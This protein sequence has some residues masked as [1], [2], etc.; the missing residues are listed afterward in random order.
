MQ[1]NALEMG[2][3]RG[4]LFAEATVRRWVRR[5]QEPPQEPLDTPR[6]D[7]DDLLH[8]D[9]RPRRDHIRERHE[10]DADQYEAS[11]L[12]GPDEGP[13]HNCSQEDLQARQQRQD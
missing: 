9:T 3:F 10:D 5:T 1:E 2:L 6:E 13:V 11:E 8:A 12:L 7:G 4:R